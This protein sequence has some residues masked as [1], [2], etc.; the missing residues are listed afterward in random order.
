MN[1]LG[2]RALGGINN[3][4][5]GD[6]MT[7]GFA[8][9]ARPMDYDHSGITSFIINH[10][11]VIYEENLGSDTSIIASKI[12]AFN[13]DRGWVTSVEVPLLEDELYSFK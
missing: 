13:P 12:N 2:E 9:I 7:S 10:Q 5:R 8:L 3:Y 1:K 4:L 11:G 6:K